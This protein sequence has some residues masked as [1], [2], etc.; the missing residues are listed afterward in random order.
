MVQDCGMHQHQVV[1]IASRFE[2]LRVRGNQ[3]VADKEK[4]ILPVPIGDCGILPNRL[5]DEIERPVAIFLEER[6]P[7]VRPLLVDIVDASLRRNRR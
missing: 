6:L 4:H 7:K 1:G 2:K 3:I 5:S